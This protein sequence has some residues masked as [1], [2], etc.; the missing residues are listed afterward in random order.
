M[1]TVFSQLASRVRPRQTSIMMAMACMSV[2]PGLSQAACNSLFQADISTAGTTRQFC[3]DSIE[4]LYQTAVRNVGNNFPGYTE[5]SALNSSINFLGV[6]VSLR[7]DQN[8]RTLAFNIPELGISQTFTGATRT[9]SAILLRKYLEDNPDILARI[10][11]RYAALSPLSPITGVGGVLPNAIL[12]DFA[13]SFAD[14]PS[15]IATSQT[16]ASQG[17]QSVL[18]AGVV[19]SSQKVLSAKVNTFSVPLSYTVRNDI[20]PRRQALL[21]ASFGMTDTAG[22]R[23]YQGRA[24][25]GYRFPMS[26]QWVLTPMA[27]LS[28]AGS[29][30]AGF[31]VG[32]LN[33]SLGSTYTWELE[34]FDVTL[35]NMLGYYQ[36][37][38]PPVKLVSDPKI[39]LTALANGVFVSQPITI[40]DRRMSIEYGLT[41][42]RLGGTEVYQKDSQ[43]LSISLGT[44]KNALSSRS[45]FRATLAFQHAKNSKG[46]SL[47][48]NYWF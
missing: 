8:S 15:R 34:K 14:S 29:K 20:D 46:V 40:S 39:R 28:F 38:K 48:V 1:N 9:D 13:S 6:P 33:G 24:S 37:F 10:Q 31:A 23:T 16:N 12:S 22:S 43:E 18:G 27:G 26:D 21:R 5:T 3:V 44:N 45:F 47:S 35:G 30:D 17:A 42:T 11:R 7:F 36:T 4:D 19:L 41:D 32:V 2:L 25:A